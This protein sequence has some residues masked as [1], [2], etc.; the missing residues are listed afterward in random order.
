[1]TK[2]RRNALMMVALTLIYS[3]LQLSRPIA[4]ITVYNTILSLVIPVIG[5]IFALN[6]K[7][8]AWRWSLISINFILW[9]LMVY[10]AFF[11]A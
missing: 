6:E 4:H 1:M 9:L 10:L 11:K 5:I 3:G 8:N 7:N 2:I